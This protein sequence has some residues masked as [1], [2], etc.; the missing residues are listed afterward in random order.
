MFA[1]NLVYLLLRS[2]SEGQRLQSGGLDD[3]GDRVPRE[4]WLP[5][6]RHGGGHQGRVQIP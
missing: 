4:K 3:H 6:R 1:S 2:R 5:S